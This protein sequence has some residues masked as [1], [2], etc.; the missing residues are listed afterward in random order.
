VSTPKRLFLD[1]WDK[2]DLRPEEYRHLDATPGP[3]VALAPARLANERKRRSLMIDRVV[4]DAE[5]L[6]SAAFSVRQFDQTGHADLALDHLTA[7]ANQIRASVAA[8]VDSIETAYETHEQNALAALAGKDPAGPLSEPLPA[9]EPVHE[10]LPEEPAKSA[11]PAGPSPADVA[12]IKT[13]LAR[14]NARI[15]TDLARIKTTAL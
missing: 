15:K 12:R 7:L 5:L 6:K 4:R 1:C 9:P 13:D 3:V 2:P 10:P 14:I 8:L 11:P